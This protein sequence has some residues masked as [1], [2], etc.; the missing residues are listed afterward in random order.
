MAAQL[1]RSGALG[2]VAYFALTRLN[3]VAI[4]HRHE[5]RPGLFPRVY[6]RRRERNWISTSWHDTGASLVLKGDECLKCGRVLNAQ[7]L[8]PGD[9]VQMNDGVNHRWI[10][11]DDVRALDINATSL[12]Q[13]RA[14]HTKAVAK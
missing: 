9:T 3:D 8:R 6:E 5:L 2:F 12:R 13:I 10:T 11:E 1:L 7:F 4:N 14:M